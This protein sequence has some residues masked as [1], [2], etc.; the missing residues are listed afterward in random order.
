M[1][2]KSAHLHFS[3]SFLLAYAFSIPIRRSGIPKLVL[4]VPLGIIIG[5]LLP[6]FKHV[7]ISH[8]RQQLPFLAS[9]GSAPASITDGPTTPVKRSWLSPIRLSL[10]LAN[11]LD[12]YGLAAIIGYRVA[13]AVIIGILYA[14]LEYGVPVSEIERVANRFGYDLTQ[15]KHLTV[16][17]DYAATLVFSCVLFPFV[18]MLAPFP[19]RLLFKI[20]KRLIGGSKKVK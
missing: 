2:L 20:R 14:L 8:L 15:V 4:G 19:A 17:A 10:Y 11:Q 13:G 5:N 12:R 7:R 1:A 16:F 6:W 9:T 18:L 3:L